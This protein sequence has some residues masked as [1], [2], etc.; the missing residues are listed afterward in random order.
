MQKFL[1]L[2]LSIIFPYIALADEPSQPNAQ[3]AVVQFDSVN[4]TWPPAATPIPGTNN[5]GK[6]FALDK[7]SFAFGCPSGVICSPLS[8]TVAFND[9]KVWMPSESI[10]NMPYIFDGALFPKFPHTEESPQAWITG[11]KGDHNTMLLSYFDGKV[12][13]PAVN[14]P[15]QLARH[16]NLDFFVSHHKFWAVDTFTHRIFWTENT[17]WNMVSSIPAGRIIAIT[18]DK[19]DGDIYMLEYDSNLNQY[20]ISHLLQDKQWD[21]PLYIPFYYPQ[22]LTDVLV[23]NGGKTIALMETVGEPKN[24]NAHIL[25]S[26]DSG[27]IWED[28]GNIP[29]SIE[30]LPYFWTLYNN[31]DKNIFWALSQRSSPPSPN[32]YDTLIY[33]NPSVKNPSWTKV[34]MPVSIKIESKEYQPA[35]SKDGMQAWVFGTRADGKPEAFYYDL[36]RKQFV[37]TPLGEISTIY[38]IQPANQDKAYGYGVIQNNLKPAALF[39]DGKAW[40]SVP[41]SGL[42]GSPQTMWSMSTLSSGQTN[43]GFPYEENILAI[44]K[45]FVNNLTKNIWLFNYSSPSSVKTNKTLIFNNI[46]V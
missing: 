12:F 42:G 4:N 18:T 39:F 28:T 7:Y 17:L 11:I 33:M 46:D 9:G 2:I 1:G 38:M 8:A 26:Q 15:F 29:A 31:N 21:N 22:L 40:K 35:V 20:F 5:I 3:S 34:S 41:I 44:N 6:I 23:M 25:L 14:I 45:Y 10:P 43:I 16:L 37:S 30:P 36:G 13:S 19:L 32:Y 27:Q 24:Q